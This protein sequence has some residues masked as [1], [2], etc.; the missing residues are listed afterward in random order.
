MAVS[1]MYAKQGVNT[2]PV[3]VGSINTYYWVDSSPIQRGRYY[4]I[5]M[6]LKFDINGNG[7]FMMWRDGQFIVNYKGSLGYGDGFYW[8]MGIYRDPAVTVTTAVDYKNLQILPT[9]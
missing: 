6:K 4:D 9:P 2:K 7:Y 5:Q 1:L 3:T 8:K